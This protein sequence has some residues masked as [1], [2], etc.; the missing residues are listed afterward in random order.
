MNIYYVQHTIHYG[1]RRD[2]KGIGHYTSYAAA[3]QA[4]AKLS[5]MPGFNDPRGSFKIHSC[6]LNRIYLPLG[7][8]SQETSSSRPPVDQY[9]ADIPDYVICLYNVNSI[10]A[11]TFDDDFFILGYFRTEA[12]AAVAVDGIDASDQLK[13]ENRIFET[14]RCYVNRDNWV[15][16]FYTDR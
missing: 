13:G 1:H 3:E 6:D 14:H 9:R 15:D 7:L 11:E 8:D 10:D 4:I 12:G 5:K 2:R 16:G